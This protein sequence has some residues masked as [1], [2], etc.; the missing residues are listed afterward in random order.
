[1]IGQSTVV[2]EDIIGDAFIVIN[3]INAEDMT[4]SNGDIDAVINIAEK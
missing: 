3:D 2:V 4:L 1:M